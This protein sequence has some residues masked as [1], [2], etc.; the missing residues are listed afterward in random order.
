MMR[1]GRRHAGPCAGWHGLGTAR[2]DGPA[3][4]SQEALGTDKLTALAD[5][6]YYAGPEI[7][8]CEQAGIN[9]LVPKSHTLDQRRP[10]L[11]LEWWKVHA[12]IRNANLRMR[13]GFRTWQQVAAVS[14]GPLALF[15]G[16]KYGL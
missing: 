6:G 1:T 12:A 13:C 7:F 15:L 3:D 4:S 5:R 8:K 2:L 10:D 11:L 9:A 16:A 14:P